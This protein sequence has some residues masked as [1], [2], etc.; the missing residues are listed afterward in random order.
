MVSSL[1]LLSVPWKPKVMLKQMLLFRWNIFWLRRSLVG[2]LKKRQPPV[3]WVPRHLSPKCP[4][5]KRAGPYGDCSPQARTQITNALSYTCYPMH[6]HG[7][8]LN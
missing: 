3:Q 6:L 5:V 2:A 8:K 1:T 4:E 7:V